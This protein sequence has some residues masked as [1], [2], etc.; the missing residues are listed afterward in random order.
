MASV[1]TSWNY[2]PKGSNLGTHMKYI[3]SVSPNTGQNFYAKQS[4]SEK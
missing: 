4:I 1:V 3:E 2:N